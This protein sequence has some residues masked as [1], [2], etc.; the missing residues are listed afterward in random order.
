MIDDHEIFNFLGPRLHLPLTEIWS[1]LVAKTE[2]G[3]LQGLFRPGYYVFKL[4]ETSLWGDNVHLWYLA[5][6]IGFA[7]ARSGG[8]CGA[9][10][11]SG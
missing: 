2:V 8:S 7:V 5:R 6:T 10:P 11:V 9:S 3:S 4:I 1:T